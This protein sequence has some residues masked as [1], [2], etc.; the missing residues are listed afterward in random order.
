LVLNAIAL[1]YLALMDRDV[2]KNLV[3]ALKIMKKIALAIGDRQAYLALCLLIEAGKYQGETT[4][5]AFKELRR[6]ARELRQLKKQR[7]SWTEDQ[8]AKHKEYLQGRYARLRF[9]ILA[10]MWIELAQEFGISQACIDPALVTCLGQIPKPCGS[11]EAGP[12][13]R[14]HDTAGCQDAGCC[15]SVCKI[16]PFCCDSSWDDLCVQQAAACTAHPGCSIGAGDC[17]TPGD[18]PGCGDAACCGAVCV[19][20]PFCC[21][22]AWDAVC[23]AQATVSCATS[24]GPLAQCGHPLSGSCCEPSVNASCDDPL[25]CDMVCQLDPFCCG[26]QWD[27]QCAASAGVLCAGLCR[28][29]QTCADATPGASPCAAHDLPFADAPGC[30]ETVC[31][32]DSFCCLEQWDQLCVLV[33]QEACG[34]TC[35]IGPVCPGQGTCTAPHD[36]P[37]CEDPILCE[38]VCGVDAFCCDVKWDQVCVFLAQSAMNQQCPYFCPPCPADINGN[39]VIDVDDLLA[40]INSWGPCVGCPADIAPPPNGDGSINVDDLLEVINSWGDCQ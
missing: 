39:G 36:S 40:V 19:I 4:P 35:P 20:D 23:A 34:P 7:E 16:D 24:C 15:K 12:C 3:D 11:P 6:I 10:G 9:L 37:G 29:P 17:C 28:P 22:V 26:Q 38:M 21:D 33:A 18:S 13:A 1:A 30:C 14:P 2:A 32:I 8:I 25:C 31:K 5:E 27:G